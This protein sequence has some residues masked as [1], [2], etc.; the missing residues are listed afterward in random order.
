MTRYAWRMRE[1]LNP[2]ARISATQAATAGCSTRASGVVPKAGKT[3]VL[4]KLS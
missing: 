1:A 4:S 3:Q 2:R